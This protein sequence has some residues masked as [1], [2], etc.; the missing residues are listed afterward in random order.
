M[1]VIIDNLPVLLHHLHTMEDLASRLRKAVPQTP[2]ESPPTGFHGV[3]GFSTPLFPSKPNI[4]YIM[5]P[6]PVPF[7]L[8]PCSR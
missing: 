2:P 3:N 8:V 7:S 4:L 1:A 5:V 6:I